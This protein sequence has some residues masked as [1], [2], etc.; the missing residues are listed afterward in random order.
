MSM[1][2]ELSVI[3]ILGMET[4]SGETESERIKE[5]QERKDTQIRAD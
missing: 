3:V 1:V 5:E 4:E 2:A